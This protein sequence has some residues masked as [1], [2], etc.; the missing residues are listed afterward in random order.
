[1]KYYGEKICPKCHKKIYGYPAISRLDNITKICSNC[2]IHE[3]I[4]ICLDY[5]KN[6]ANS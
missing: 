1:M 2:G 4:E 5:N 3:A 6:K